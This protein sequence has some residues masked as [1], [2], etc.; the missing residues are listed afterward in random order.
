[1]AFLALDRYAPAHLFKDVLHIIKADSIA[2]YILPVAMWY[3]I[4]LVEDIWQIF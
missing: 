1:M 2:P 3:T 4:E